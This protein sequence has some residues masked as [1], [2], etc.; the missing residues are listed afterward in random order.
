M[1]WR[2]INNI[3]E[4]IAL[5]FLTV[6]HTK[7]AC[8]WAFGLLK[9]KVRVEK[10]S[11]LAH[12]VKIVHSSTPVLKLNQTILTGNEQGQVFVPLNDWLGYFAQK[13]WKTIKNI[14][15]FNHFL[16]QSDPMSKGKVDCQMICDGP[17]FTSVITT[18][19]NPTNDFPV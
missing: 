19:T 7:F 6:G 15:T 16:F 10:A 5:S 12:V 4:S 17:K 11:S 3:N 13:D 9:Q 18:D 8:D 14:T 1:A 2:V